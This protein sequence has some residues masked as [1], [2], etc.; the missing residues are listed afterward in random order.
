MP[1]VTVLYFAGLR[2][3]RGRADETVTIAAGTT[4]DGLL[5][6]LFPGWTAPVTFMRNRARVPG[7]AVLDDGDE[8]AL[9]PPLGGG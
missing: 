4:A 8:V 3:A 9:L 7:S 2:E 5:R 1:A 6:R